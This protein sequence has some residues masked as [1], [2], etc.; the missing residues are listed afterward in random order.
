MGRDGA[1]GLRAVRAAGGRAIV[2]DRATSVVYGMPHAALELAGAD[3]V[4]AL[5]D[6]ARAIGDL[7]TA[8]P[9]RAAA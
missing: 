3:R 6:V 7:T 4:V 2:Q 5:P 8:L 1:E 9:T